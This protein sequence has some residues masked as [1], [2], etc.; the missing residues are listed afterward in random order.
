MNEIMSGIGEYLKSKNYSRIMTAPETGGTYGDASELCFYKAEGAL[1]NAVIILDTRKISD[2]EARFMLISEKIP[3]LFS[4]R[5]KFFCLGIAIGDSG[6]FAEKDDFD[7]TADIMRARWSADTENGRLIFSENAPT[8]ADG[9]E[10]C[11][12]AYFKNEKI[13]PSGSVEVRTKKP[14]LTY[15]I[16]LMCL[17]MF[18]VL[19]ADGGSTDT[20][21]LLKYGALCAPLAAQG[22]LYR[23]FTYMFL[24]IGA[25][26]LF[27]NLFSLYIFGTRCEKYYGRGRF[28]ILYIFGGLGCALLSM[29]FSDGAVSAGASGAIMALIGSALAYT[30]VNKIKMDGLDIY[31]YIIFAL[32]NLGLGFMISGID[33]FGHIGGFLTGLPIGLAYGL[34]DK[35]KADK[36]G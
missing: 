26:H 2:P 21:V 8:K 13:I 16:A 1:I 23:L 4:V 36:N 5:M 25:V 32:L 15:V 20:G 12:A 24:H 17:C 14:V 6:A 30:A 27:S 35:R 33:N 3:K 19:S 11:F 7:P 22:E 34:W 31:I 28:L 9:I 18:A 10:D 29:V